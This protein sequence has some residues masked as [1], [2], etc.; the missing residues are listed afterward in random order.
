MTGRTSRT[1]K[2]MLLFSNNLCFLETYDFIEKNWKKSWF[3]SS[4]FDIFD[5]AL[6]AQQN[7]MPR[8]YKY[9]LSIFVGSK[10]AKGEHTI[11]DCNWLSQDIQVN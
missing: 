2:S 1:Q 10:V 11:C 9:F 6:D 8:K 4:D 7:F 5:E 3:F